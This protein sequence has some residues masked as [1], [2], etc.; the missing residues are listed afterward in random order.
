MFRSIIRT[1]RY[2]L[3]TFLSSTTTEIQTKRKIPYIK[4]TI[5]VLGGTIT[6]SIVYQYYKW[7]VQVPICPNFDRKQ[8]ISIDNPLACTALLR[9]FDKQCSGN[10]AMEQIGAATGINFKLIS[11]RVILNDNNLIGRN[12]FNEKYL[13]DYFETLA[14]L[15]LKLDEKRIV[16]LLTNL[17]GYYI[18]ICPECHSTMTRRMLSTTSY[19][20]QAGLLNNPVDIQQIHSEQTEK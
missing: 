18:F 1:S 5:L 9:N 6:T 2:P 20:N 11:E 7:T 12:I 19:L 4:Y 14:D 16:S 13:M 10:E 8:T 17:L 3:T 15:L